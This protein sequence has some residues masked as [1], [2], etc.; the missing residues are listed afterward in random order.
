M[1]GKWDL[2]QKDSSLDTNKSTS[3]S[4]W[5]STATV[6]IAVYVC[7]C[8]IRIGHFLRNARVKNCC[9]K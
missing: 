1:C 6:G 7:T 9:N 8:V 2:D 5:M 4:Y 3:M